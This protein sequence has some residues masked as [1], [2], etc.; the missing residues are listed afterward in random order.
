M[1]RLFYCLL[2]L[3]LLGFSLEQD[4]IRK[5]KKLCGRHLLK[6][7]VK[8]CGQE[9]WSRFGEET[10]FTQLISQAAEKVAAFLPDE[11]KSP[12]A[13][14]TP[15]P[16]PG[17]DPN[18]DSTAAS[19]E[20][21]INIVEMPSLPEYQSKK[22]NSPP[23]NTREFP[24]LHDINSYIQE[25]VE[26][27]KKNTKKIKTLSSLFWGNHPQR[28]RRGYSEKCC[29]EGC[30][31]GELSIACIPY[32]NFKKVKKKIRPIVT[33]TNNHRNYTNLIKA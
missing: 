6:E 7:I 16:V 19:L 8:L 28:K 15:S 25:I 22:A 11:F 21:T 13:I 18:P 23:A 3:L 26:F 24:S 10:P 17:T 14:T 1:P 20:K 27:Q 30:T 9:D 5:S 12:I 33:Y 31:K 4:D 32:I 2:W 29:L